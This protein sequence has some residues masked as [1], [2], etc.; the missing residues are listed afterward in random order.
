MRLA[1]LLLFPFTFLY[2]LA[3]R[4]RNHLYNIGY[5]RSVTFEVPVIVVGNLSVGGTGKSPMVEYLVRLLW[6]SYRMAILSRGYK[7]K[8]KGFRIAGD[9]D[10]AATIGDEPMQYY[11]KWG[12]ELT[13]AVGEDRAAAIPEILFHK[14]ETQ[15]ILMDDGYQ[16]R[17]VTPHQALLLTAY[18]KLF[19]KDYLL[20]GG[21]LR[22]PRKE[23][24]RADAIIVTRCP[25]GIDAAE[26]KEIEKHIRVYINP[27]TRVF[28][29]YLTYEQPIALFS[30]INPENYEQVF[31]FSGIA[32]PTPF[33]EFARS[34]WNVCGIKVYNDHHVYTGREVRE[35]A[36]QLQEAGNKKM[37]LLTT[38]KDAVKLKNN[39]ET[40][41][42]EDLPVFYLPVRMVFI[43]NGPEFDQL[44]IEQ[45]L[46]I[47]KK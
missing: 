24:R 45:I 6:D 36:A 22:E 37:M 28:F 8:T 1:R 33:H 26:R 44:I 18:N 14:P 47:I 12:S 17:A 41:L 43:E 5:S 46:S 34:R 2:A 11:T 30:D 3:V 40:A 25:A 13:V 21:R 23:A 42:L 39:P 10:H 9:E 32:D 4:L 7:R 29:A 35:I 31:L 27:T 38:E 15:V 16:H 19:Y 20:P